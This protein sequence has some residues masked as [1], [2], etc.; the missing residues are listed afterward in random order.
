MFYCRRPG[1]LGQTKLGCSFLSWRSSFGVDCHSPHVC[2]VS[3]EFWAQRTVSPVDGR[4][5][6][7]VV[8]DAY[9]EHERAATWLRV[10][11]DAQGRSVGTAQAYAGRLALY[12]TW[13]GGAGVEPV[14]PKV[15]QLASFARRMSRLAWN[16]G[17]GPERLS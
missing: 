7:T 6:W 17:D 16:L 2:S 10:L 3:V 12:L 13:A 1:P 4:V 8:D 11:L 9:V 5:G 15:D 14:A